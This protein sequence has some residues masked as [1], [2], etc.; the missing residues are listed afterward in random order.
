MLQ[1]IVIYHF[2]CC[3]VKGSKAPFAGGED[4][5]QAQ[6]LFC[7][8]AALRPARLLRTLRGDEQPR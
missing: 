4:C 2:N 3:G 5:K 6:N 7:A 1:K 8:G